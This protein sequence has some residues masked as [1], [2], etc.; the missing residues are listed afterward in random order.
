MGALASIIG[1]MSAANAK[2]FIKNAPEGVNKLATI[3]Q[4]NLQ[5]KTIIRRA[6]ESTFQFPCLIPNSAP[7]DMASAITRMMDRVYAGYTQIALGNESTMRLSLDRTPTQ[8]LK[9]FHQNLKFEQ[10]IADLAVPDDMKEY[11]MERVYTGEYKLYSDP[12]KT[13]FLLVNQANEGLGAMLE[14]CKEFLEPYVGDIHFLE[15]NLETNE[16]KRVDS[17][18]FE[19]E[20]QFTEADEDFTGADLARSIISGRENKQNVEM[21]RIRLQ[22]T[23]SASLT[24]G[25]VKRMNDMTPYAIQLRLSVV[26][27]KDEFVQFMDCVVGI[28]T[29]LHLVDSQDMIVNLERALQN[30]SG[31]FR[32]IKWTTGEISFFKDLLLNIDNLKF[33]AANQN[34]GKS[35]LFANLKRMKQKGIGFSGVSLPYGIVPNATL[36]ITTYEHDYMQN[37]YGIELKNE[38]VAKQLMDVLNLMT[39]IICDDSLGT[40][41]IL[42]DGSATFQTYALETIEREVS[43]S[44]NKLGREIG[45][46]L[47]H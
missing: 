16:Y 13:Y 14:R 19:D 37:R 41:N 1:L 21:M 47:M 9:R 6:N 7:I 45:R 33:D 10:A 23:K 18:T 12:S 42:Y 32:F 29:V 4:S 43:L 22:N 15:K 44:S 25:D 2:D 28:K 31:L 24:E 11:Y 46:M 8:F 30:K 40:V 20:K 34:N 5:R 3:K 26:N 38:A 39:F 27:D 17:P 35:P 36:V